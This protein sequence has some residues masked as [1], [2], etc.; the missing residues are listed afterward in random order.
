MKQCRHRIEWNGCIKHDK[1]I[2]SNETYADCKDYEF[3]I[4]APTPS[5]MA[6]WLKDHASK[7]FGVIYIS[8]D[9]FRKDLADFLYQRMGEKNE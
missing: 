2:C 9:A 7:R 6:E 3:V 4:V 1:N 8:D 5:Q